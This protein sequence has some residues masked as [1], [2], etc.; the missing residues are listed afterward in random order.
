MRLSSV[1]I[2]QQGI[3]AI[4]NQQSSLQQTQLQL[5]SGKRVNTP[6]DDPAAAVQILALGERL[7]AVDQYQRNADFAEGQLAREETTLAS[8]GDRLQRVRELVIQ[9]NNATQSAESRRAIATEIDA[10]L[11]ALV[12]LANTTDTNGDYIFAG[13]QTDEI[14]FVR[15]GN[16]VTYQ[17]DDGQR[18]VQIADGSQ[19]AVR[20]SGASVFQTIP[21]GQDVFT[22]LQEIVDVLNSGMPTEVN[23]VL[24]QSLTNLDQTMEHLLEVR[25]DIGVRLN[26]VD[27]QRE[28]NESFTL[29]L[30]ET[31]SEAQ[32]LDYVEAISRFN[33]Q[34]TALQAAQQSYVK[35]QGLSLFNYL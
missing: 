29:Q 15:Q 18:F 12:A 5:T 35:T 9:A 27:G 34:L 19:V 14:P 26:Q 1:Q 17:G 24:E 31:L 8:V 6:S 13:F 28:I 21:G 25:A 23:T 10:Q 7:S 22:T 30:Q 11:E 32:D 4:L 33:L 16:V 2:F 20:D 3:N